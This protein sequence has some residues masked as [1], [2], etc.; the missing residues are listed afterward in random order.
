MLTAPAHLDATENIK[1]PTCYSGSDATIVVTPIAG[2]APYTYSWNTGEKSNTLKNASAGNYTVEISDS[3]GCIISKTYTIENPPKD[4]IDLGEDVTL[5][6]E[7][8]LTINAKIAD[9]QATYSWKSDKG[10]SS[11]KAMITVSEPA[12]YTVTVTNKLGCEATDAIQ[13]FSQNTAISAEFAMSS[14]VFK[15]E[16]IVIVDIS[17]PAADEIEWILPAKA[18]VV[19]K[20]KDYA[21]ISF[22]EIGEYEITLNTKKGNCTAFQTKQILVTEGEYEENPDDDPITEKKFDLK[23][24]PNPSQGIFTVDVTLDKIMPAHVKVY[25]LNNNLLIDSKTEEGKDN[26]LF[27]FNLGGLPPGLYFVLFESQQ[28]SKLRKIIIQ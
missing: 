8:T 14:Q 6:W 25:N 2:I 15:N 21:E 5:C 27:N 4:V 28:G 10:F 9:D 1:N 23:I 17:N 24:Y 7:Q 13:I 12:N 19:T 22:S 20:N 11:N 18:N 3:K 26:Y 16:K